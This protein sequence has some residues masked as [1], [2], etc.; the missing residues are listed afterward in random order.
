MLLDG[1]LRVGGG[2]VFFF[3]VILLFILLAAPFRFCPEE[4]DGI[5]GRI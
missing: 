3:L 4:R 1:C 2:G 5:I